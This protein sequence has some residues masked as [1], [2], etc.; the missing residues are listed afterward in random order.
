V[1]VFDYVESL[2][3]AQL[4][5]DLRL[6]A[7]SFDARHVVVF[8]SHSHADHF[9]PAIGEWAHVR[10][11]IQYVLGSPVGHLPGAKLMQPHETWSSDGVVVRTTASTDEGV[12]FLVSVDGLTVYHAGDHAEWSEADEPE[13]MAEIRWLKRLRQPI[14][15]AFFPIATG[16]SCEP[17]ASIWQGVRAA[18]LELAPRVLVPMHVGCPAKLDLYERFRAEVGPQLPA[19]QVVAPRRRGESFVYEAGAMRRRD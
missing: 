2:P 16:A 4:P 18:A 14:D 7:D 12:G 3:N 6:T 9:S 10:P 13:F 15:V 5:D 17:R 11:D 19:T 8:V 1:L